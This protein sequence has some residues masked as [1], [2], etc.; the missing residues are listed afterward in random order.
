VLLEAQ[1]G[2]RKRRNTDWSICR[3]RHQKELPSKFILIGKSMIQEGQEEDGLI[4][5]N[6]KSNKLNPSR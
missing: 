1:N 2:F 5:K 3:G 4:F 6:G